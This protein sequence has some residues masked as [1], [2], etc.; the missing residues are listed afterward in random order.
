MEQALSLISHIVKNLF[1]FMQRLEKQ[2]QS[3]TLLSPCDIKSLYRNIGHDLFLT[4]IKYW[5]E[6]LQMIYF[7]FI[8]LP[9]FLF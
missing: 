7:Y 6:H 4:A 9:N 3:T 2:C 1:D 5:V 8:V